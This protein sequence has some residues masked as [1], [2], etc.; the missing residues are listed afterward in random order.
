MA[1]CGQRSLRLVARRS[2]V[3]AE[4][5]E[6]VSRGSRFK[7]LHFVPAKPRGN[8]IQLARAK[9]ELFERGKQK[10]LC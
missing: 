8:E 6:D 1:S 2:V 4:R 10:R 9:L 7:N 5:I 3:V